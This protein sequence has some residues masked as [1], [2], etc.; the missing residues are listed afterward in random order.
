MVRIPVIG[1]VKMVSADLM[2]YGRIEHLPKKLHI[3]S[4]PRLLTSNASHHPI[5]D[6]IAS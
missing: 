1:V 6:L 5:L 2:I 4:P 3:P